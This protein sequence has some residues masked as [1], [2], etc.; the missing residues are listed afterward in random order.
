MHCSVTSYYSL[1]DL[2]AISGTWIYHIVMNTFTFFFPFER[3]FGKTKR[4]KMKA[5]LNSSL[6]HEMFMLPHGTTCE[7]ADIVIEQPSR[8]LSIHIHPEDTQLLFH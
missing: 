4:Y 6:G 5:S 3:N 7:N 1:N 8:L 2:H